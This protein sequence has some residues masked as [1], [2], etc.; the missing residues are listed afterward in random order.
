MQTFPLGSFTVGRVGFGAMQLPGPGV[1]G[2]PRDHDQAIAVLRRAIELGINH[3][4]TAQFY[5]PNVVQRTDPRGAAPLPR[6]P[7]AGEQ[8]RRRA[9]TNRA[10][11]CPPSSPTS[12]APS[13]EENLRTLGTD[14]LAAVNLRVS[15]RREIP[16]RPAV[17]DRELFDRQLSAMIKARDEGLIAGIGLS[18][19]SLDH[20]QIALDRTEIVM[21]AERLQPGRPHVAAGARRLHRTRHRVRAVLPA[22]L[23]LHRRQSRARPPRRTA[24]GGEARPHPGAD[25]ARVDAVGRAQRAAD[26]R[27]LVGGSTWRRTPPSPTSNSTTTSSANSTTRRLVAISAR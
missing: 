21:R 19:I 27:H 17:V 22:R 16:T 2:P 5:G 13:I 10:A 20:L 8:G 9:A 25:R 14:R 3:I 15:T 12:C 18:S 7:R 26:S 11:G 6:R 1:F 23:G 24:R 4:D